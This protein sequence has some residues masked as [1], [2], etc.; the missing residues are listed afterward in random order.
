V[1]EAP[2]GYIAVAVHDHEALR[3]QAK[4]WIT[5]THLGFSLLGSVDY[6]SSNEECDVSKRIAIES[7]NILALR[8]IGP[9]DVE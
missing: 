6:N 8:K 7:F 1:G 5:V 9:E 2:V 3:P 4:L